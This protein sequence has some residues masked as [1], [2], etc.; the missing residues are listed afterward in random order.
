MGD[1]MHGTRRSSL[2]AL[3]P[4][5]IPLGLG[6][7]VALF[8]YLGNMHLWGDITQR[9]HLTRDT[10]RFDEQPLHV[11][12]VP[13]A[14]DEV[15]QPY[16]LSRSEGS[17]YVTYVGKKRIDVFDDNFERTGSITLQQPEGALVSSIVV[18]KDRIYTADL[19]L[20]EIRV[21][22]TTG[23][24]VDAWR[25]LPDG[26]SRIVPHGITIHDG[27]MYV[28]DV[29][30]RMVH[31]ISVEEK[32]GLTEIGELLFSTP[33]T[34][35]NIPPLQFPACTA[36]TEDGRLLVSDLAAGIVRVFTCD[37]R[38]A[39]SIP[40]NRQSFLS[41]PHSMAFDDLPN[42][43]FLERSK[44]EFDPSGIQ[45]QGRIHVVDRESH[46]VAVFDSKGNFVLN[47]GDED[48]TVP[49]GIVINTTL[50]TIIIADTQKG[51]LVVY[52]Y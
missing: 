31:A 33:G 32:P 7:C 12:T 44:E 45:Y 22:D 27:I 25:W 8:L 11:G 24:L 10:T 28:T 18:L 36:V 48:L 5:I 35:K 13:L 3:Y 47:Y 1:R 43:K 38:F 16:A 9:L 40:E 15:L 51:A 17:L 19:Q 46:R 52:R 34:R 30:H 2:R 26:K 41:S 42:P 29:S 4:V 23:S 50:R 14:D 49:N 39:Y 37:G 6:V 21:H 20:K